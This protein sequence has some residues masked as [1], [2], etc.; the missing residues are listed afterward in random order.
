MKRHLTFL[1]LVVICLAVLMLPLRD[2]EAFV[3]KSTMKKM[4]VTGRLADGGTFTGRLTV[5]RL[6]VDDLDQL[7]AT[8]VLTGTAI[9]REGTTT[10]ITQLA[11]NALAPLLDLRGTCTTLFLDLEPIFLDSLG[12]EVALVPVT[13]DLKAVAKEEHLLSTALCALARLQG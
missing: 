13:L 10:K 7:S 3:V 2:S 8:G 9:T 12:Q 6:T 11:F 4:P 5:E 1:A